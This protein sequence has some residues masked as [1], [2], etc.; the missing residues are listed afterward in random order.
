MSGADRILE[1]LITIV[2]IV[3]GYQFYFWAQRQTFRRL[4]T[5]RRSGTA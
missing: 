3:G 2:M 1:M 5:S 4:V